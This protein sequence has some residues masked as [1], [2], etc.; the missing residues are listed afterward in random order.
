MAYGIFES[1]FGLSIFLQVINFSSGNVFMFLFYFGP[2]AESKF[3]TNL[4][5]KQVKRSS[6][7]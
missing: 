6:C 1:N 4:L 7:F 5:H 2:H 3:D